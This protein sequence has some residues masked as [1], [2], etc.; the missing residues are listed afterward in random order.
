MANI[1]SLNCLVIPRASPESV[2]YYSIIALKISTDETVDRLRPM[3]KERWPSIFE[4]TLPTDFM[5]QKNNRPMQAVTTYIYQ[6]KGTGHSPSVEEEIFPYE[7]ISKHFPQQP[8]NE[9]IQIVVYV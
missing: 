3:I 2:S 5:L 1:I 7:L 4:K 9:E 6:L 8:P